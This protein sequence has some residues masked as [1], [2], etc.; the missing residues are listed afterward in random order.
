MQ[1]VV[2][3]ICLILFRS[4]GNRLPASFWPGIGSASSW[5]R[6][7]LLIG[8]GCKIGR[9]CDIEPHVEV[10]FVPRLS[11]GFGCQ[12]NQN[13]TIRTA[14][15]GKYV[16]LAPGVVLLDRMHNFADPTVPMA[17]QGDSRRKEIEIEDDV[18]IGQNAIIMPGLKIGTGAIIAA[19]A[20]VTRDVSAYDVVGGVPARVIRNR[21]DNENDKVIRP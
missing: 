11:I 21:I 17:L 5:V 1:K 15:L 9:A 2:H 7:W 19:G 6:R 10:G 20:V 3:V 16:M 14:R 12:I 18:W 13:V 4:I 8:M